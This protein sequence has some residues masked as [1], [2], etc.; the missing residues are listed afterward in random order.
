MNTR[1]QTPD[2]NYCSANGKIAALFVDI[3]GTTVVCQPYFDET[4]DNFAY[5]MRLRGFD[6][7]EARA[8]LKDIDHAKTELEGF[9]R[10]RYGRSLI[11]CYNTMVKSKRR[12]FTAAARQEDERILRSIGMAP[13]FR[14]PEVFPNAAPVLGRAHHSFLILAVSIGNREAQKFK[15]RQAGLDPVFDYL[16]ITP[17]DNKVDIVRETIE[18]LNIDA[19]ASAFIGNSLR[20]DGACLAVTNFIYLPNEA[21]WSFDHSK[22]VPQDTGFQMFSV[23]DWREA[24]ERGINRLMRR[25]KSAASVVEEKKHCCGHGHHQKG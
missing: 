5:F 20:S 25:R 11:E 16:V 24:E 6:P 13:Y 14:Q 2:R 12:R 23:K 4:A 19:H 9:E 8:L 18:D 3:D 22:P 7:S 10:D 1:C 21:G 15:V 17:R